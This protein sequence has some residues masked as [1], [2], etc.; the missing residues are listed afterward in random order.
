MTRFFK[1]IQSGMTIDMP[2][3]HSFNSYGG[4]DYITV[5]SPTYLTVNGGANLYKIII[6]D[7]YHLALLDKENKLD[8]RVDVSL[9][10]RNPPNLRTMNG[11]SENE[12]FVIEMK[13][14]M[15]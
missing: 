11:K 6:D 14:I 13:K 3:L 2:T 8:S 4:Y 15:M 10:K 1:I 12:P 7:M 9:L 5:P